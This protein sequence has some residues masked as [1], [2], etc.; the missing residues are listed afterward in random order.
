MVKLVD[1]KTGRIPGRA[2]DSGTLDVGGAQGLSSDEA[3]GFKDA[4]GA[5]GSRLLNECLKSVSLVP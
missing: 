3:R 2:R 5:L 4:F 1:P